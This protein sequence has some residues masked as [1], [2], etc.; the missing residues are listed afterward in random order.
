MKKCRYFYQ[1]SYFM[2]PLSLAKIFEYIKE[3]HIR[4]N[5]KEEIALKSIFEQIDLYDEMGDYVSDKNG[6]KGDGKLNY[7][8]WYIFKGVVETVSSLRQKMM[9][10]LI[11]TQSEYYQANKNKQSNDDTNY[12]YFAINK[13]F[14]KSRFSE[15]NLRKVFPE[16]LYDIEVNE[17]AIFVMDK[18]SS[19]YD[20]IIFRVINDEYDGRKSV[21]YV[22]DGINITLEY[23]KEGH[24]SYLTRF[25]N[26][27]NNYINVTTLY[28]FG[29]KWKEN[30]NN[31][32]ITSYFDDKERLIMQ[33][34]QLK[35]REGDFDEYKAYYNKDGKM[36]G[37]VNLWTGVKTIF[38]ENGEEE[39][40]YDG[41]VL[42]TEYLKT[43]WKNS[44]NINEELISGLSL[45]ERIDFSMN[46]DIS[47]EMYTY[48]QLEYVFNTQMNIIKELG[49]YT[50]DLE[51]YTA[52]YLEEVKKSENPCMDRKL[53]RN[54]MAF[55][56]HING[57]IFALK[58]PNNEPVKEPNG[59]IDADF[60]Q[61][62]M[63][64]C[65][66]LSSIKAIASTKAGR[67]RLNSMISIQ[68]EN[69]KLVSV[70]VR[71]QG[72]DY[73]ISSEELHSAVEYSTGDLD[74]RALEI[75]VNRF[76]IENGYKDIT[77]GG[78]SELGFS[79]LLGDASALKTQ[80]ELENKDSSSA[81][82]EY[83]YT[84]SVDRDFVDKL[85]TGSYVGVVALAKDN[86]FAFDTETGEA[87][88]IYKEHAY[89]VLKVDRKYAY[90]IN[91]HD[92]SKT[93]RLELQELSN[94]FSQ[95][96]LFEI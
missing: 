41:G 17:S 5:R 28:E 7:N 25:S 54:I 64:D 31:K 40:S 43:Y 74:V 20:N 44:K 71:L 72:K 79:I 91:P 76:C 14:D 37:I 47:G 36:T 48:E 12:D 26:D 65:W 18:N 29:K 24:L 15:E 70:T 94:A 46:I 38:N 22:K 42:A 8:E 11:E 61:G 23:D 13:T 19:E 89:T 87:V 86:K 80:E 92:S 53:T 69:G 39:T 95:G 81:N 51:E 75:A 90:L 58:N 9:D 6:K 21:Y 34:G 63:G 57:R 62:Y 88:R 2:E 55:I 60:K 35:I 50:K 85:K 45:D 66:L 1:E 73:V 84:H 67:K 4:L 30:D 3:N 77:A 10:F 93:M 83:N 27:R 59:Q 32:S 16:E 33:Q 56:K 68:K 82:L 78:T 96:E 49:G 52:K